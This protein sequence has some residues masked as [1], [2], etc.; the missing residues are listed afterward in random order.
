M[1]LIKE[2]EHRHRQKQNFHDVTQGAP[3]RCSYELTVVG[4]SSTILS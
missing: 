2:R 1:R 4:K 3:R